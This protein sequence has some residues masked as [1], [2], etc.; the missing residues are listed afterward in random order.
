MISKT[1]GVCGGDACIHGHR[2]PVW[3]LVRLRHLGADD[4]KI[5]EA[6]PSITADDLKAAWDYYASNANEIDRDIREN[7]SDDD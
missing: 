2:I 1:P 6:Y 3:V 5:L 4:A 7:E